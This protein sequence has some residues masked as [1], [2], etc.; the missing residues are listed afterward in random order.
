M[1]KIL[2]LFVG[3]LLAASVASADDAGKFLVQVEGGIGIPTSSQAATL[4]TTGFSGDGQIGYAFSR[5]FSLSLESGFD[6]L[7]VATTQL[8]H[9]QTSAS[10]THVPLEA[11]G[12]FN[13]NAGGGVWP[14]I[15]VGVGVAFDS[16][17]S[18][19][20]VPAGSGQTT[21]WTNFELDPG[22]GVA[23]DLSKNVN[24]FVQGKFDMDFETTTGKGGELS[25]SPLTIIPVQIGV[26]FL[27]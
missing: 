1:K 14:Y 22:I 24:I 5:D 23:V 21:S 18:N 2:G 13:I 16:Y 25:D 8:G 3:L 10:I 27:I 7:P 26:N 4:L 19:P 20:A 12:Q 9:G 15:L 6:S 17:S 11:V